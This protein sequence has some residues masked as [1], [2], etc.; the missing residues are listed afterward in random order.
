MAKEVSINGKTY[1][2]GKV[3]GMVY[4]V[5][6]GVQMRRSV[7]VRSAR[8]YHR[9]GNEREH[10]MMRLIQKHISFHASTI[11]LSFDPLP[12]DPVRH[13][14]GGGI[15]N[16][17]YKLNSKA[18]R[19]ALLPLTDAEPGNGSL[20]T[21][22]EVE[23]AIRAYA[24]AHPTEITI[25][26]KE[27]FRDVFLKGEWPQSITLVRNNNCGTETV[28]CREMMST[29]EVTVTVRGNI[30][31]NRMKEQSALPGDKKQ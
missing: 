10:A 21:V 30:Y 13:K 23:L 28:F 20:V 3:G 1:I 12:P 16:H 31:E 9:P 24:A 5:A 17:Y 7:P 4:Y 15:R 27:G 25:A 26:R 19:A 18:L 8:S 11:H 2:V 29:D 22:S 6:N 14:K